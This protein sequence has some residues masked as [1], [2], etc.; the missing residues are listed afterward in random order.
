[1]TVT[2][3]TDAHGKEIIWSEV[4]GR[5]VPLPAENIY[6]RA[7]DGHVFTSPPGNFRGKTMER[8]RPHEVEMVEYW[9]R[10]KGAGIEPNI[11]TGE[12]PEGR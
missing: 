1:M 7:E 12:A 2:I 8:L 9:L 10:E 4:G 6:V 3:K 5:A 11:F